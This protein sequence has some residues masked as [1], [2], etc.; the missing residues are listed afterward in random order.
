MEE[1]HEKLREQG[2]EKMAEVKSA[3][4]EGDGQISVI[5]K[6]SADQRRPRPRHPTYAESSHRVRD[7]DRRPGKPRMR[8]Y[9][10]RCCIAGSEPSEAQFA[11]ASHR[12]EVSALRR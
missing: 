5:R 7:G 6:K 9:Q 11:S 4:L 12:Q 8:V 2:I 10:W 1:L 3:F